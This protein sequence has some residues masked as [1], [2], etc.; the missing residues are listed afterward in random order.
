L[1]RLPLYP[2]AQTNRRHYSFAQSTLRSLW[3]LSDHD[4]IR[5]FDLKGYSLF[6]QR[7]NLRDKFWLS[8]DY[9]GIRKAV[10]IIAVSQRTKHDLTYYLGI[11]EEGISVVYNGIDHKLFKPVENRLVD[12]PYLLFVGSEQPRKNFIGLL[13]A[14]HQL[15]K[16]SKFKD[17]KLVKVGKA[18]GGAEFREETL[19]AVVELE[20]AS[21]VIFT[22][23]VAEEDL[24]AYYSGAEC[25]VLPS[26][27][28]GFGFP[29][30]EAMAC[31][32]PVIASNRASLPE[33]TGG[34]AI[35]FDPDDIEELANSLREVLTNRELRENLINRGLRWASEFSW[36][37]TASETL[38]VYRE[39]EESLQI[40]G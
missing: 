14:F 37:K 25:F 29:P 35:E 8:S 20:L 2:K 13:K 10:K 12:Y 39:V 38:E 40:N 7:S 1:G 17:L 24:P 32:C 26:Y 15:K 23:Y 21:E 16:E 22:E 27:Y 30:L 34:T 31:G 11:P 36:E 9:R 5:Y 28:E 3:A 4:L 19:K 18:G 33:I 6:I